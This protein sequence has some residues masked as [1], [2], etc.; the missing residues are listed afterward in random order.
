MESFNICSCGIQIDTEI[1]EAISRLPD[2]TQ[3]DLS[4]NQVKDKSACIT[5]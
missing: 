1:A 3:L 4:G 2:H 5:L